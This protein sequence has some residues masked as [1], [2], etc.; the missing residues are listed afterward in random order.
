M[1]LE[2]NLNQS[3][4]FDDFNEN[5]N[6][7][8]VLFRPGYAVQAREL[9]QLQTI[10]Q[11][12]IERF[13]GEVLVDGT[14]VT[15][16]GLKV[17]DK[18]NFVKLRDKDAN[19]RSIILSDFTTSGVLANCTITGAN[20]GVTADLI[21]V[22]DGSE[23]ASPD[24]FSVFVSYT[25]SGTD[26]STKQFHDNEVLV[27][28]QKSDNAFIVAANTIHSTF[29]T[30]TG[31]GT[32][33]SVQDG[34]IYHKGH[35]VRVDAQNHIVSKYSTTPS[36]KVG[37]STVESIVDSN[38][39]S[40]LLDNASGSTNFAAPGA[41]RLKLTPT[42][43]SRS[44]SQAN[45]ETF[46]SI[47]SI[48]SG[49][50]VKVETATQYDDIADYLKERDYETNGNYATE[51]FFVRIR[52]HLKTST[53]LGKYNAS[54]G[55]VSTKLVAEIEEGTGYVNGTRT[56]INSSIFRDVDKG[57]DTETLT[58][59]TFS[60]SFGNYVRVDQVVGAWNFKKLKTVS[61]RSASQNAM[62]DGNYNA[63][64]AQGSEIGTAKVRSVEYHSGTPGHTDGQFRVYLFDIQ[65]SNGYSFDDVLG[66]YYLDTDSGLKGFGNVVT[67]DGKKLLEASLAKLVFPFAR[68]GTKEDGIT[69]QSFVSK[70][71]KG[72]T[73]SD[74]SSRQATLTIDGV[75]TGGTETFNDSVT[76]EADRRNFIIVAKED[77]ETVTLDGTASTSGS[78]N[79]VTGSGTSFSTHFD[80]GDL[81]RVGTS[82]TV[83]QAIGSD[84]SI[85]VSPAINE[86]STTYTKVYPAG[87]IFD[88][89]AEGSGSDDSSTQRT[90]NVGGA[91]VASSWTA[92][93][94]YD[95][96]RSSAV[97][98]AK[99]VNKN[100]F[101][102]LNLNTH[103]ASTVGPWPLGV[104]DG[105]R[106]RKVYKGTAG[107]VTT[108]NDD[109]TDDFVLDN[110][111][112]DAFYDLAQLKLKPTSPLALSGTDGLLV[113]FDYFTIDR[114][115]GTGFFNIN[116]YPVDD[117]NPD[118][119]DSIAIQDIP[120][121]VSPV[122]GDEYDLRDAIDFRQVKT[123][124][125][126]P[127]SVAGSAPTNPTVSTTFNVDVTYGAYVP[128]SDENYVG[129]IEAYLSRIDRVIL[130]SAGNV[131]IIK[132]IASNTPKSPKIPAN[133]MA[134][135]TLDI[136]PYP[137]LSPA[138]AKR[139]N[140]RDYEV[141][142]TV[143]NNR[144]YT[145]QDLR[146]IDERVKRVEYFSSLNALEKAAKDAQI[147][148]DGGLDRF[149]N[150]FLVDNFDGLNIADTRKL[151]FASAIDVNKSVLRPKYSR[152]DVSLKRST[153]LSSSNMVQKNNSMMLDYTHSA[154]IDQR[155]AS[156]KRN[157]IQEMLFD[158][159]GKVYLNPS[160]D[161]TP[162]ITTLPDIQVDFSGM[163]EAISFLADATGVKWGE[164][165]DSGTTRQDQSVSFAS[166]RRSGR[167]F[168]T[169]TRTTFSQSEQI[170]TGMQLQVSPVM[171]NVSLGTSIRDVSIAEYMRS[172]NVTFTGYGLRP[173]TRVYPY[174]DKELVSEF[175][176]PTNSSYANTGVLGGN[177]V[178][179]ANGAVFGVF[180]IPNTDAIKFRAGTKRF[181]LFDVA[182]TQTESSLITT[183]AHADYTSTPLNIT[184]QGT[185]IAVPQVSFNSETQT[186]WG[187]RRVI[188]QSSVT[189]AWDPLA[190][191]FYVDE[192]VGSE[193]EGIFVSK[194]DLYFSKKSST[195]PFTLEIRGVE[196]GIPTEIIYT[197]KTLPS[198]SVVTTGN[199]L[200]PTN[201]TTFEFDEP[202]FL[203]ARREYAIVAKPG[204]NSPDYQLW[205]AELG[206]TDVNTE[207]LIHKQAAGG[208]LLSSSN[209]KSW[210]VIQKEDMMFTI[211][212]ANFTTNIGTVYLENEDY[213][214]F[215]IDNITGT[216]VVGE[217]VRGQSILTFANNDSVAVG[218]IIKTHAA[219]EG[220]A[221]TQFANGTIRE[222]I[223]S[224]SGSVT[225]FVDGY[226]T[227]P[228]SATSAN[229]LNLFVDDVFRGNTSAYTANTATGFVNFF[230]RTRK[231]L[232]ITDSSGTFTA[233]N[234][235]IRGQVSGASTRVTSI[236]DVQL[237]TLVPK[238]PEL[239]FAGTSTNWSAR[240][241]TNSGV[242][243][244]T[245]TNLDIDR[246]FDF[247]DGEKKVYSKSN[248]GSLTAVGGSKKT[249]V[250]K[251][252][253]TTLDTS[254]S[255]VIDLDRSNAY[256]IGNIINNTLVDEQKEIG[257]S[258]TRYIS[259]P[260]QLKDGQEAEDLRV[261]LTAFRPSSTSVKV[262]ARIH[263][264][265]DQE[266]LDDKDFTPLT[267]IT[268]TEFSDPA[269]EFDYK[270]IEFGF[271]ANTNGQNFLALAS[272][273]SHARLHSG[274]N[275]VVAYMAQDGSV[276]H[277]YKTFSIKIV[278]T[279]SG[280]EIVPRVRDMRAIALQQ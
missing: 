14:V 257:N 190:Q 142:L 164:W 256:V 3:P 253:F 28:R 268:S 56:K 69:A 250:L 141:R 133:S 273:N 165:E 62:S 215:T 103:S 87:W 117:D 134:I 46:F 145:M 198:S 9:T 113:E 22:A 139:D 42:L 38:Q 104:P 225:V 157:P 199:T 239:N 67:V 126:T 186:Q 277:T 156:K 65:M 161:N 229:A 70:K 26:N 181:E 79:T 238:I 264:P 71:I 5:K 160:M 196:N 280:T 43:T 255:P 18:L 276:Y 177:L 130:T 121:F 213:D 74:D 170:R 85:T 124:T 116:S 266:T 73:F 278:M 6:F 201:A 125:A 78:S 93:V 271:S 95:A 176:I 112:R 80:V 49:K 206:G 128:T 174:F 191:T 99:V 32:L 207:E 44:I 188:G 171:E 194:V 242:I 185:A 151:G 262:Y 88:F 236:D 244:P 240:V 158:W 241:S 224:G 31:Y 189:V 155:F 235:Y 252:E 35:F 140:R 132:G 274:N 270:E 76:T 97:G 114:S 267:E 37:F 272:A 180:R 275:N 50:L 259:K 111:Q 109:V 173:N 12:Q 219:N 203:S 169:A 118:A 184:Q 82:T 106:L 263:N 148:T 193:S 21:A 108:S 261:Y 168:R 179:D 147:L 231:K 230:D 232:F 233:D 150:G 54:G 204:G 66:L 167:R 100:K 153:T 246:G 216:F 45:T 208:T 23:T 92:D 10:L 210:S 39:D 110:G 64:S 137:S 94:Y 217:K 89:G 84:T 27:F 183:S 149:K 34:I 223:T 98:T 72:V 226:G 144:R 163:N 138:V 115:A 105:L 279:A 60:V 107:S 122:T 175:C 220:V 120:I 30:S 15:G 4:Y 269:D 129:T 77:V 68:R 146:V 90:I 222:I 228:T 53:N 51:P 48:E 41:T 8:R 83:I 265:E 212:K 20:S 11:N 237:N 211:H 127:N 166:G 205:V 19:T 192:G 131:E 200:V 47:G 91:N 55:G 57:N 13:A 248:E 40:S 63:S 81:I 86:T 209:D 29:G 187:A 96:L 102:E 16:C 143:D 251:G 59:R 197:S 159:K 254:V 221:N 218:Q 75:A 260:V 227:F 52:E 214:F 182:N 17:D 1:P 61:L 154:Y 58:S 247:I 119:S 249:I 178:T 101:V 36:S 136:P 33:A 25:N 162:D 2:T 234:S 258:L 123:A 243:S 245:F 172:R 135:A 7:H 202:I 152:N 195:L 24:F